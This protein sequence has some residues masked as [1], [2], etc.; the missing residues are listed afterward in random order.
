MAVRIDRYHN[1]LMKIKDSRNVS[2]D[3]GEM[4]LDR[5]S[6]FHRLPPRSYR[7]VLI[8]RLL[9]VRQCRSSQNMNALACGS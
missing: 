9:R 5:I 4:M 7:M 8:R 2:G 1:K 3:A 6:W